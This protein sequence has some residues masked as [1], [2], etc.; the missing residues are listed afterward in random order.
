MQR[1]QKSL[2]ALTVCVG[3]AS[4]SGS[5]PPDPVYGERSTDGL[6][7]TV[8]A[9]NFCAAIQTLPLP[10]AIHETRFSGDFGGAPRRLSCGRPA[11]PTP[12]RAIGIAEALF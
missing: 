5:L 3:Q 7:N 4:A 1:N 11:K 10:L 2:G 8:G 9:G 6:Q 12:H